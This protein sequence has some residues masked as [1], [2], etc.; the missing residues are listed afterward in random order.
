MKK[1]ILGVIV[2]IVIFVFF[3]PK[4]SFLVFIQMF[5]QYSNQNYHDGR[6]GKYAYFIYEC[7]GW[8]Y[9]N[10]YSDGVISSCVGIPY[11]KKC[12]TYRDRTEIPCN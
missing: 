8:K 7:F 1:I 12:F 6:S 11:D 5:P 9:A 2:S 10:T 4:I 3:Q